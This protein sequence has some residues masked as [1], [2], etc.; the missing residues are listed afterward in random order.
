LIDF[1]LEQLLPEGRDVRLQRGA[2]TR[3]ATTSTT[4]ATPKLEALRR[5]GARLAEARSADLDRIATA[6]APA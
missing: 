4:R 2:W 1:E 5:E 3:R 6:L